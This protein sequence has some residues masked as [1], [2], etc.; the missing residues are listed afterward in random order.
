MVSHGGRVLTF[1]FSDIESSTS[2]WE[3][4]PDEMASAL[5]EHDAL[6]LRSMAGRGGELFKH[7]GDGIVAAF[8]DPPAAVEAAVDLMAALQAGPL[9][10]LPEPLAVRMGLHTGEAFHRDGDYF[11]RSLNR[12]ARVMAAAN[13]NQIVVSQV[14]A[15]SCVDH[16]FDDHGVHELRGIGTERLFSLVDD[17]LNLDTRPLRVVQA[18]NL[19]VLT[20]AFVGRAAELDLIVDHVRTKRCITLLGPGGVGKTR[21]SISVGDRISAQYPDGTWLC[22]L[23]KADDATSAVAVVAETL[24][25]PPGAGATLVE[26]I[27]AHLRDKAALIILDNC[28][29]VIDAAR[30][31]VE[32]ILTNAPDCA[33]LATSREPLGWSGE[34]IVPIGPLD[35]HTDGFQL[36][37]GRA[38]ERDPDF[39]LSDDE[40]AAARAL[41]DE[42]DGLPLAIE[43][44]SARLAVLSP[45]AILDRLADRFRLL[46]G[47]SPDERHGSLF[48]TIA[49]SYDLLDEQARS[50]YRRLSVFRGGFTLD[51][52]VA[53]CGPDVDEFEMLDLL[54]LLVDKS[55]IN[56]GRDLGS[57]RFTM[58]ESLTQFGQERL[59]ES[60]EE[61]DVRTAHLAWFTRLAEQEAE[62]LRTDAEPEAW[63]CLDTEWDNLRAAY[64]R[65]MACDDVTSAAV[66][67]SSL[68]YFGI[69]ALR[70]EGVA[71][72]R[73]WLEHADTKGHPLR[74][75]VLAA[76]STD[77]YYRMDFKRSRTLSLGITDK[78]DDVEAL[79]FVGI[80]T[81]LAMGDREAAG[82]FVD[83]WQDKA[84]RLPTSAF[85]SSN[86]AAAAA[87]VHG[88]MQRDR[89][90]LT[91]DLEQCRADAAA[92]GAPSPLLYADM[93][94]GM[95][96]ARIDPD[97]ALEALGRA[98]EG[99]RRL[100]D[101]HAY[102]DG[103]QTA[104]AQVM[105][106]DSDLSES[107]RLTGQALESAARHNFLPRIGHD[108]QSAAI[109]LCRAGDPRTAALLMGACRAHGQR[110]W[111]TSMHIVSEAVGDGFDALVQEGEALSLYDAA[112]L[113]QEAMARARAQLVVG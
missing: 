85:L 71:W 40:Q 41:C 80:W 112:E 53:V 99:A 24:R 90:A 39:E 43:L 106:A 5:A 76:A 29:H 102:I 11:G 63:E 82:R 111:R 30:D 67:I 38:R 91:A 31:L 26:A 103:A 55:I 88:I 8:D 9:G 70:F 14:T 96:L 108:L 89:H 100:S 18:T 79:P 94:E 20:N 42:L 54:H 19:P 21:L 113:A 47:R 59:R 92:C 69:V 25:T 36:M 84:A 83:G 2:L 32:A 22:R 50:I 48:Q 58:L 34:H 86:I 81:L 45:S 35:P 72:S 56:H 66:I 109:T 98:E 93:V 75:R 33:V 64:Q 23:D 73:H 57:D 51:A 107:L 3:Q 65:A 61:A 49:W 16:R 105:A 60:G 13:G 77:A 78:S 104:V 95:A 27:G 12:A 10:G 68:H 52:A 17:R 6:A 62:R 87:I 97:A 15:S 28:E 46:R 4:H 7:T 101:R 44:A 37:M 1:L 74:A 110:S